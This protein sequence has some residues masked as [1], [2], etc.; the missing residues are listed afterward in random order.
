MEELLQRMLEIDRRG[1]ELVKSAEAKAAAIRGECAEQIAE[2]KRE[3]ARMT[4]EECRT[5]RA[6][7]EK[8]AGM[9][10]QAF[11][12][13]EAGDREARRCGFAAAV[14]RGRERMLEELLGLS[15]D[16]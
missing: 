16:G 15:R 14:A 11:L 9:A 8:E 4:A 3:C 1:E 5:V 13:A 6:A 10:R 2:A 12:A 7:A